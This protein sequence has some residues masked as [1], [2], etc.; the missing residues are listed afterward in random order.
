MT[1]IAQAVFLESQA[2]ELTELPRAGSALELPLVFDRA[3]REIC[4]LAAQ[5][6]VEVVEQQ[7]RKTAEG[8]LIDALWFRRLR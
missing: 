6:R 7:L 3:A 4:E 1:T 5:G 8:V 2:G